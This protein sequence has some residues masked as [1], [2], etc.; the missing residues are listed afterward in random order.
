MALS[1]GEDYELLLCVAPEKASEV[2]AAIQDQTATPVTKIGRC[3]SRETAPVMIIDKGV[4]E[5]APAAFTHF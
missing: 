4:R 2:I 1:G 5:P 3:A